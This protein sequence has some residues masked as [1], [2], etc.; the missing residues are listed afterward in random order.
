MDYLPIFI[1]IK[2]RP[3]LVVGGG[4]IAARKVAL[5]RKAEAD[6][7]VVSPELCDE[8]VDL[9]KDGKIKHQQR[10]FS[11][12][13]LE[14]CDLV[15]AA[16]DQRKVNEHVSELA[17]AQRLPVN[18]VDNPDLC[19][20]IM[21]SIIDRSPVQI[22]ISTGGTS[23]VLARMLR[24]KLEGSIPAAYGKLAALAENFRGKVKAAFPDVESR[25]NFWEKIL[26][27]RVAELVFTGHD[28]EAEALL[29]KSVDEESENPELPGEV[30]LVGAGP[31]D[32]DLLT[33]RALRLMQQADVVV[34]DRLVSPAI[35]EMVRRDAEIVYV[36]K[37]R[38]K[39]TMQQENIN[40]LLVRLAKEG[41][42]VLRLKGG[43]PFIFG[44]GGEEIEELAQEGVAFQI[45]P[46]ITAASGCSSY[47]GIPLTHRD[48]AQSCVFV[49]GHLKDGSVDLNWK[50]LAHPNQTV[51]FYM[52]L[53]GAPTLCKE[54]VAHGL[55]ATTPVAL[56]EQGTT[57][58][59]RV[60]TA[61]LKTLLD[62][63]KSKDIKPP[64]LIIVGEVV[65]LHDKLKWVEEHH[66]ASA[67]GVFA[68]KNTEKTPD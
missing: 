10:M 31:G 38:D 4:S 34:Y 50:A 61:T 46:G 21:P 43:D 51:V 39:H 15:I 11:A 2:Q 13:D 41:K 22:A 44:R 23:P 35:M 29:Q 60:Y 56:V 62:V 30:Y 47:A 33:F 3:C 66:E 28:T 6:V 64:T 8:L 48:Y 16:T 65:T 32:P 27:G 18:V 9:A 59:Q 45:V 57:P 63:I 24:T 7:T 19:S 42:R 12:S 58:Q 36:G 67:D 40:Q 20:F 26:A 49:T 17:K 55:P 14:Q 53:H 37:E 1:Q 5:L 52:G 68:Y 54:M 25:R